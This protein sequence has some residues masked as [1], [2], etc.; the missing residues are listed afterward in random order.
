MTLKCCQHRHLHNFNLNVFF[1]EREA[2][3]RETRL[4]RRNPEDIAFW[5][6]IKSILFYYLSQCLLDFKVEQGR[7]N[8]RLIIFLRITSCDM[9]QAKN[10]KHNGYFTSHRCVGINFFGSQ[11]AVLCKERPYSRLWSSNGFHWDSTHYFII[12]CQWIDFASFQNLIYYIC[13]TSVKEPRFDIQKEEFA[14]KTSDNEM[15]WSL[16]FMIWG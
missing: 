16:I 8:I 4:L 12:I 10:N 7:E 9:L 15:D 6:I 11:T 2:N 1:F 13:T 3:E 5:L 14:H